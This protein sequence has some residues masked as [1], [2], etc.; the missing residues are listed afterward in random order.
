MSFPFRHLLVRL[1]LFLYF[2]CSNNPLLLKFFLI[3]FNY[4]LLLCI[5]LFSLTLEYFFTHLLMSSKHTWIKT[6]SASCFA[7][8]QLNIAFILIWHVLPRYSFNLWDWFLLKSTIF[9]LPRPHSGRKIGFLFIILFLIFVLWVVLLSSDLWNLFCCLFCIRWVLWLLWV[10]NLVEV[11]SIISGFIVRTN[12]HEL[13]FYFELLIFINWSFR[14][15]VL[16]IAPVSTSGF[17][18][19]SFIVV[20]A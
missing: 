10:A 3:R 7:L 19:V 15:T 4:S 5:E 11:I 13:I 16:L 2:F 12:I 8:Y 9:L 17:I 18:V 1:F 20:A 6:S 14:S